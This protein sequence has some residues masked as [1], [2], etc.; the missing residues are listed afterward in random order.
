MA[1]PL[2][3]WDSLHFLEI[4]RDGYRHEKQLAFLPLYPAIVRG[5]ASCLEHSPLLFGVLVDGIHRR[6]P[7]LVI[8]WVSSALLPMLFCPQI[9]V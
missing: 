7:S 4:A 1:A 6:Q 2:A 5:G 8:C 9:P 3:N